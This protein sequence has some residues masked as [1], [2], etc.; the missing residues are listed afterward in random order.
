MS[1]HL[2][3]QG[4]SHGHAF[5]PACPLC[6]SRDGAGFW[7]GGR[8]AHAQCQEAEES[9]WTMAAACAL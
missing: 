6:W 9:G 2:I 7:L 4:P 1:T 8:L 5:R 3:G